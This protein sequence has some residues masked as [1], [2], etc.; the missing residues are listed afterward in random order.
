MQPAT[1]LPGRSTASLTPPPALQVNSSKH[2][3]A[4]SVQLGRRQGSGP[5]SLHWNPGKNTCTRRTKACLTDGWSTFR[6][7]QEWQGCEGTLAGVLCLYRHSPQYWTSPAL[8]EEVNKDPAVHASVWP[9]AA[10]ACPGQDSRPSQG[11]YIMEL[12]NVGCVW[13]GEITQATLNTAYISLYH[14]DFLFSFKTHNF[15]KKWSKT[16]IRETATCRTGPRHHDTLSIILLKTHWD[17]ST[18]TPLGQ[19]QVWL[20]C[21]QK[22]PQ[23]CQFSNV[24]LQN[25]QHYVYLINVKELRYY[26]CF[27]LKK[28]YK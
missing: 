24:L 18:P 6:D 17:Q 20:L 11:A 2:W 10:K 27:P 26:H 3:G 8:G 23:E 5:A 15:L 25:P 19:N 28:N 9:R 16:G 7:S 14:L 21:L 22:Y 1:V 12:Q 4:T 13:P